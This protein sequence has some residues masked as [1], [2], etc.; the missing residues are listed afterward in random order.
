M[1]GH[2]LLSALAPAILLCLAIILLRRKLHCQFP[3]FFIYICYSIAA[4]LLRETVASSPSV[5]FAIYW[6][7]DIIYGILELLVIREVFRPSLEG[8][9]EKYRWVRWI[10]PAIVV[11][12]VG[13]TLWSAAY[14]PIGYGPLSSLAAGAYSFELGVRWLELIIFIVAAILDRT[15]RVSFLMSEMGILAGLGISALLT[16]FADLARA[17]FG[18]G[19]EEVFR[20]LPTTAYIGAA[21]IWLV[22]FLYKEPRPKSRLTD[23]QLTAMEEMM[24]R[25]QQALDK[26]R[27]KDQSPRLRLRWWFLIF[28]RFQNKIFPRRL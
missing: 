18:S 9:P 19:F 23:D 16:L 15:P 22:A 2:L 12:V 5:Y 13:F 1:L 7:T 25:Q 3:L 27:G 24:Q 28:L 20:Y 21:G 6:A 11:C 4:G 14:H 8:F 10:M 26:L 17:K